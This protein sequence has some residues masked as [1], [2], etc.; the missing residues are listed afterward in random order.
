[1]NI[2]IVDDHPMTVEGFISAL[3]KKAETYKPSFKKAHDC[4]HAYNLIRSQSKAKP[5]DLA[6]I[7]H[8]LP[9]YEAK[10]LHSG[11]DLAFLIREKM[12]DCKIIMI[13][14]HTEIILIYDI[15]KK[16]R[17]EGL[18]IKNDVT[19]ENLPSIVKAVIDGEHYQSPLVRNSINEIWKKKL[20]IDDNNR[21]ILFYLSKG[22]KVKELEPIICLTTSTIQKRIIKMKSVFQ[23]NDDTGLVKEAIKQGFI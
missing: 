4:Q 15:S 19:P 10:N 5:F 17:P 23:V 22:F 3:S 12:P 20:M 6:I 9:S 7:D 8:G 21:Q 2:L 16:I 14:A 11:V 18:V 13:T 1:M